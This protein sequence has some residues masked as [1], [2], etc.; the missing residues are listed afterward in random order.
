MTKYKEIKDYTEIKEICDGENGRINIRQ[1]REAFE[2]SKQE[3]HIFIEMYNDPL[4]GK[5]IQLELEGNDEEGAYI[6]IFLSTVS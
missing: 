6:Y 2:D 3:N 5:Y 4:R 1:F